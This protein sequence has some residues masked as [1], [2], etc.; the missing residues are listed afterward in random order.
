MNP[1]GDGSKVK[2]LFGT[3]L[4]L[5]SVIGFH[6]GAGVSGRFIDE[7]G[8]AVAGLELAYGLG[9]AP[10]I[11]GLLLIES[12]FDVRGRWA[13]VVSAIPCFYGLL[14]WASLTKELQATHEKARIPAFLLVVGILGCLGWAV[15]LWIRLRRRA[16]LQALEAQKTVTVEEL[17]AMEKAASRETEESGAPGQPGGSP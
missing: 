4:A 6:W 16:A 14:R 2:I 5:A 10:L 12:H 11:L 17:A 15:S 13:A 1:P 9:L 7:V 3:A 8:T